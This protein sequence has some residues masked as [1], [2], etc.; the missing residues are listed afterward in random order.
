MKSFIVLCLLCVLI[1]PAH[2]GDSVFQVSMQAPLDEVYD[3]D[4]PLW[5]KT[6]FSSFSM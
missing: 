5:T 4:P 2:A 6:A 1:G 3:A